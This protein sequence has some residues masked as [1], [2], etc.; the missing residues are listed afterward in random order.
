MVVNLAIS[1]G[2]GEGVAG[3]SGDTHF[4][5]LRLT[6]V[7]DGQGTFRRLTGVETGTFGELTCGVSGITSATASPGLEEGSPASSGL[8]EGGEMVGAE[9]RSSAEELPP[10]P[11]MRDLE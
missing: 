1:C 2:D 8:V 9:E 7:N 4:A 10:P 5:N 3:G 6:D 11:A